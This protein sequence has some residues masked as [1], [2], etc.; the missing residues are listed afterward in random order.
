MLS[1]LVGLLYERSSRRLIR[2]QATARLGVRRKPVER[3]ARVLVDARHHLPRD[4]YEPGHA[5]RRD[6]RRV[7]FHRVQRARAADAR[8]VQALGEVEPLHNLR[9]VELGAPALD[10]LRERDF[11]PPLQLVH[12]VHHRHAHQV[13]D[14][15]GALGVQL[16]DV[17]EPHQRAEGLRGKVR[18][19]HDVV[20]ELGGASRKG[21]LVRVELLAVRQE[22]DVAH[23]GVVEVLLQ[24]RL[25]R[26]RQGRLLRRH[27]QRHLLQQHV[28]RVARL[29]QPLLVRLR[30]RLLRR[31]AGHERAQQDGQPQLL[32]EHLAELLAVRVVHEVCERDGDA[33]RVRR[34]R[35]GGHQV[36]EVAQHARARRDFAL[37]P[38]QRLLHAILARLHDELAPHQ[39]LHRALAHDVGNVVLVVREAVQ[40]ERG[41][42]LQVALVAVQQI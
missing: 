26:R 8:R 40:R 10:V 19:V 30:T 9:G 35:V 27:L 20:V 34:V 24:V 14:H 7:V 39:P 33:R 15:V 32:D 36:D 42:V 23:L 21:N 37:E 11:A 17:R 3:G 5:Q 4:G 13:R 41:V 16:A 6:H 28:Q 29:G 22:R 38:I 25:R 18:E 1:R 2:V 12:V 31:R